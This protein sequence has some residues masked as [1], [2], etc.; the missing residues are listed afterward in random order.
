MPASRTYVSGNFQLVLDGVKT[1]FLKSVEGGAATAEVVSE[2][3]DQS[4][5]FIKK[6]LGAITY[7]PLVVE[8]GLS[9]DKSIYDWISASWT[10]KYMRKNGAIVTTDQRM[11]AVSQREF[12]NALITEV[13]IPACDGSSKDP[14]YLTV[15]FAPEYTRISKASGKADGG[16]KGKQ[17]AW[18]TSN[19]R[20]KIGDLDCTRIKSVAAFSVTQKVATDDIGDARDY[21]LEPGDLEFPNLAITLAESSA[22]GWFDWFDSFVLKGNNE[23][24]KEKNGSISFLAPNLSDELLRIDLFNLGIFKISHDKG[25]AKAE[26]VSTVTAHL[27][28]ERMELHLG[29]EKTAPSGAKV[30]GQKA[31]VKG[32]VKSRKSKGKGKGQK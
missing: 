14:A 20:V 13:G 2:A 6:H 30:K 31:K 17:K 19:F 26:K 25:E 16:T 11:N 22:K 27:Y 28:C 18:L 4:S 1:G 15:K 3:S 5:P 23:D 24:K 29:A 12:F 10:K 32:Q 9:M 7:E 8:F 21:Q